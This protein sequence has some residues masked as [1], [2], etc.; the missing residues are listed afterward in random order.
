MVS[1]YE[2]NNNSLQPVKEQ[3]ENSNTKNTSCCGSN[4]LAS[5]SGKTSEDNNHLWNNSLPNISI[6]TNCDIVTYNNNYS[7][8][9]RKELENSASL[10][11]KKLA[12]F[13]SSTS[14]AVKVITI[15]ESI[16]TAHDSS[17]SN[18]KN[19]NIESQFILKESTDN[20]KPNPDLNWSQMSGV[21]PAFFSNN[22]IGC[23]TESQQM[24]YRVSTSVTESKS[25][26]AKDTIDS[27][28]KDDKN[29]YL[30][31]SVY[32]SPASSVE[33]VLTG[34]QVA[35]QTDHHSSFGK[36]SYLQEILQKKPSDAV[37]Y[38]SS[39]KKLNFSQGNEGTCKVEDIV[40]DSSHKLP[41]S[42]SDSKTKNKAEFPSPVKLKLYIPESFCNDDSNSSVL[43]SE[44][45][46]AAK[47]QKITSPQI[48]EEHISKIIS[49]N[50]AI[51]ETLDPKWSR[52]YFKQSSLNS[53][54]TGETESK[55][56]SFSFK[57]S[58]S[59]ETLVKS[60]EV[61][62][63][64][65]ALLGGSELK[66]QNTISKMSPFK[67][68]SNDKILQYSQLS[69]TDP[70]ESTYLK[71]VCS[72]DEMKGSAIKSLLGLKKYRKSKEKQFFLDMSMPNLHPQNPEGSIIKDLLLKN[73]SKEGTKFGTDIDDKLNS[74]FLLDGSN[75]FYKTSLKCF[76]CNSEFLEKCSLDLHLPFCKSA[77][78][79]FF[80]LRDD[81]DTLVF[82]QTN[83]Q[84]TMD[85]HSKTSSHFIVDSD[86]MDA[87]V[88]P[89]LKKQLLLPL[90]KSPPLKRRKVS[91]S[92]LNTCYSSAQSFGSA[93]Y[94][95]D[96]NKTALP[97]T[98]DLLAHRNRS[99]SV[100]LFGG[101]VQI[102]DGD[103]TK[104]MKIK[105][106]IPGAF[107][108]ISNKFTDFIQNTEL[109][110]EL[111]NDKEGINLP[112]V[113]VTIAQPVHNSGGTVH[114]PNCRPSSVSP[115]VSIKNCISDD[116]VE[117]TKPEKISLLVYPEIDSF[118]E[119]SKS[120]DQSM[121]NLSNPST[122]LPGPNTKHLYSTSSGHPST[123]PTAAKFDEFKSESVAE[124]LNPL[125][126]SIPVSSGNKSLH[127]ST[128]KP[129]EKSIEQVHSSIKEKENQKKHIVPTVL[130]TPSSPPLSSDS[131]DVQPITVINISEPFKKFLAPTRPTSLP[132]KKKPFTMVGSTLI[133]P[134]TPRPKKT[135]IQL[136]LNGHAYTYLGLKCS[137]RSTY[138][139]I[140]RPQPMYV[141][142]ETNP[143]LSMYSNWQVVPAKEEL[144][145]LTP[146]QM[147]SLYCSKQQKDLNSITATAKVGEPL[148]FTHSSYWT[149]R[150]TDQFR[151]SNSI[152]QEKS[153]EIEDIKMPVEINQVK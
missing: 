103:K 121:L 51:V 109:N 150:S 110:E 72:E 85:F 82:K 24:N 78:K 10:S 67:G 145:G 15:N 42:V 75:I 62:K 33:K 144:C 48:L 100:H 116:I 16:L 4:F 137:T 102:V 59:K 119:V 29:C 8:S 88:G 45:Q 25:N 12:T 74:S 11:I 6:E 52:R 1:K 148:I 112:S 136:Y 70:S 139:C 96:K 43:S 71:T 2:V 46:K 5:S 129:N 120:Q 13:D 123:I 97:T 61:S 76:N 117:Y 14:T 115:I 101:E 105:T 31:S 27:V 56:C 122:F 130:F 126:L 84:K 37:S 19:P 108:P 18:C 80:S 146:G 133:S 60:N 98:I 58:H 128:F 89:I 28:I 47:I 87:G 135:C 53:S 22:K 111:G 153:N 149:Y 95:N 83:A 55:K 90:S 3:D 134:E 114:L 77:T 91:D 94:Y 147:I 125:T 63:L 44:S 69:V 20:E 138:C 40:S 50:A 141:L 21:S 151:S 54:L 65:S 7:I 107:T 93:D 118:V 152:T 113:V 79:Q 131:A 86:Q 41:I 142:Q 92:V 34:L 36:V 49:E 17:N 64:Q 124:N 23:E 38:D 32:G 73:K 143:K 30:P 81:T 39:L 9:Y 57:S 66:N 104:R 26:Q 106:S 99:H 140:Y 35:D 127:S 68:S 132:L